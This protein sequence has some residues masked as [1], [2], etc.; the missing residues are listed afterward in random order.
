MLRWI[1]L[2]VGL[3]IIAYIAAMFA[4]VPGDV[5]VTWQGWRIETSLGVFAGALLVFAGIVALLYRLWWSVRRTPA[6]LDRGRKNRRQ[7]RGFEALSRGLVAVAAGDAE[8][9]GTQARRAVTLLDDEPL[10]ML[11]S[12]QAAQLQGDD[13]AA[14]RFFTTMRNQPSTEFLGVRGLLA[15]AVRREDWEGALRLAERAYQLNPKNDWVT[16]MLFDLQKRSG[17]WADAEETL[18]R[19]LALNLLP[20]GD[21]PRERAEI[22]L[23]Q[24]EEGAGES[25]LSFAKKAFQA[26]SSYAPGAV[27]YARL[28]IASGRYGRAAEVI[29]QT[30]RLS[31]D[32]DLAQLYW[33]ARQS[34]D[35]IAKVKAAQRLST[36]NPDHPESRIAIAVAALEARLWGEARSNLE[37][38]AGETASPRICR[39]M[40]ELEEAEHGD[41]AQARHWLMRATA[42]GAD[43]ANPPSSSMAR[44]QQ[45]TATVD[46]ISEPLPTQN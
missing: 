31:P 38:I 45:L 27:R 29:E 12:A 22:L 32:A 5:A 34:H 46:P 44:V 11:L 10:T 7:R 24:S 26:D 14:E 15:Q 30:W 3:G 25:S 19:R 40:A 28:L 42:N 9:A 39:L 4:E 1:F 2:V 18:K 33:E 43:I 21:A 20:P 13:Q 35:A 37:T 17:R 41:L 36:F 8:A 23:K 6:I 16:A